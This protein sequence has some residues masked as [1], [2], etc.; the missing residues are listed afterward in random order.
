M[1]D[2]TKCPSCDS[3][4][5]FWADGP[6]GDPVLVCAACSKMHT[7]IQDPR[8]LGPTCGDCLHW[9]GEHRCALDHPTSKSPDAIQCSEWKSKDP[10]CHKC[11]RR[12]EQQD[13]DE[14]D[15]RCPDC[16]DAVT[17]KLKP[18]R[19][20]ECT[21]CGVARGGRHLGACP[22]QLVTCPLCHQ[23]RLGDSHRCV[24]GVPRCACDPVIPGQH[25]SPCPIANYPLS[26]ASDCDPLPC[27][28]CG[29]PPTVLPLT[30][31]EGN[32][33]GRVE[34]RKCH[35]HVDDGEGVCDDRGSE[36][37]KAIAVAR[38]NRL[39][40]RESSDCDHLIAVGADGDGLCVKCHATGFPLTD[41]F[42]G[43]DAGDELE[44]TVRKSER[45]RVIDE[46]AH[47][48]EDLAAASCDAAIGGPVS[49]WTTYEAAADYLRK[50]MGEGDATTRERIT[51]RVRSAII[52]KLRDRWKSS[53]E[54]A[55][56]WLT[57][58]GPSPSWPGDSSAD[59]F[60]TERR[61]TAHVN[62]AMLKRV[63]KELEAE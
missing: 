37:Y 35:L 24:A 34:C 22:E 29:S 58:G 6:S 7:P 47:L 21:H 5:T 59:D 36:V 55:D 49:P 51:E 40:G 17:V 39:C 41:D 15:W 61:Y 4:E 14:H 31:D 50:T 54:V 32:A 62:A 12:L 33:W 46:A 48:L 16:Y 1:T 43:L 19:D 38:W 20:E 13:A 53:A 52:A 30:K 28:L 42:A 8:Q 10:V 44:A 45:A 3:G 23:S 11:D 18:K 63:I 56:L 25:T 9:T 57:D 27:P 60:E 26:D 2:K